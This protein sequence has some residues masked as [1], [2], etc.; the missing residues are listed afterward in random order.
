[1][2]NIFLKGNTFFIPLIWLDIK[3]RIICLPIFITL[4]STLKIEVRKWINVA[5]KINV[6]ILVVLW[7]DKKDWLHLNSSTVVKLNIRHHCQLTTNLLLKMKVKKITH[8]WRH[9]N[10]V[11]SSPTK[12]KMF[13][14]KI[15]SYGEFGDMIEC[16]NKSWKGY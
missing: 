5:K 12:S 8:K 15:F 7:M 10:K 13:L 11:I 16:R 2:F 6:G 14:V 3:W 9:T 1:M 4:N